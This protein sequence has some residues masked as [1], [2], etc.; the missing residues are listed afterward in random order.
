MTAGPSRERIRALLDRGAPWE[1]CDAFRTAIGERPNDG[2]LLYWGAL[3]HARAGAAQVAHALLDKAQQAT[4]ARELVADIA[5]LRGR[6]FKDA[7]HR[8][9]GRADASKLVGEAREQYQKAYAVAHDT[10]PGINAAALAM[11]AGDVDAA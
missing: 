8:A 2:E 4:P 5:S 1:A 11:L 3:A 6:L 7:F 9:P 10:H